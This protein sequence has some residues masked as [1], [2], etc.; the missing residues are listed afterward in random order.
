MHSMT[1]TKGKK[2]RI[3]VVVADD[4]PAI[5][6]GFQTL[7]RRAKDIEVVGEASNGIEA[8][9]MATRIQPEVLV[10]DIEMPLMDGLEAASL[11]R[12]ANIPVNVLIVSAYADRQLIEGALGQG[13]NGYMTKDEA[14]EMIVRA[15]RAVANN[16]TGWFSEQVEHYLI[17]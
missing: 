10:L 17:G 8:V 15:V 12:E 1:E 9:E 14:P 6:L 2:K 4:H 5:R 13:V 11:I 7:L 16:E 3:R